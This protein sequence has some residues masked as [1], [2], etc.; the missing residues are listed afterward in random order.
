MLDKIAFMETLHSVQ[1]VARTS[2]TPLSKEEI[3]TYFKDMELTKEQEEMVYQYL[4]HPQEENSSTEETEPEVVEESKK[5]DSSEEKQVSPRF[6]M[7][8]DELG[9]IPKISEAQEAV[10]YERLANGEEQVIA[11]I[12]NQWLKK[13]VEIASEYNV[14]DVLLD[15]MVQE[16]NIGLLMGLQSLLGKKESDPK[17]ALEQLVKKSIEEYVDG[18]S[19]EGEQENSILAKVSL[20]HEAKEA[21]AKELGTEPS[22]R[23]LAEYTKIPEEEIADIVSLAKEV[24]QGE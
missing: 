24:K 3:Q 14:D 16:G 23:Q 7:Y 4:L 2:L 19:G 8:L 9:D 21:L 10:L 12:S 18:E 20:V 5:E 17:N 22:I 1:E 6:Q 13:V 11:E 15:D